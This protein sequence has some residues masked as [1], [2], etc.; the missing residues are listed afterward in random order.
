MAHKYDPESGQTFVEA[1]E[2]AV[3][4]S[5]WLFKDHD[6]TRAYHNPEGAASLE[7]MCI[8]YVAAHSSTL[9]YD[10]L[11]AIPWS[12]AGEKLWKRIVDMKLDSVKT[13]KIFA[14]AY[15]QDFKGPP[16]HHDTSPI[17][18]RA[19]LVPMLPH[20]SAPGLE[21]LTMLSIDRLPLSASDWM[22]VAK[23]PNLT[24]LAVH[25]H[26]F[27][28]DFRI[29]RAWAHHVEQGGAF[30]ELRL[31]YLRNRD[32]ELCRQS[33]CLDYL[34]RIPKLQVLHIEFCKSARQKLAKQPNYYWEQSE[35]REQ[36]LHGP[37]RWVFYNRL[38]TWDEE[39]ITEKP[40]L[41]I[42]VGA[43]GSRSNGRSGNSSTGC[44]DQDSFDGQR[45]SCEGW[46]KRTDKFPARHKD[47]ESQVSHGG[48]SNVQKRQVK[49]G[50]KRSLDIML[51]DF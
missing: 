29:I 30:P 10:T 36:F 51:G 16:A 15:R 33:E 48:Q 18:P 7:D 50:V 25:A 23:M 38:R 31:L 3:S 11:C 19:L 40:I 12:S 46:F 1:S 32:S 35:R 44:A 34:A 26:P 42:Q 8:R 13:W 2:K 49:T 39:F 27:T 17:L 14:I 47:G 22:S 43:G 37:S 24:A 4:I 20:I 21:W 5:Q 28:I 45:R 6:S 9:D 41:N